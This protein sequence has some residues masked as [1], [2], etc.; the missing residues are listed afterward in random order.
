MG[1]LFILFTVLFFCVH[2]KGQSFDWG[3]AS[4]EEEGYSSQKIQAMRDTLAAHKTTSILVISNDKIILEWYAPGWERKQHGTAS[5][6]KALVGGMSLLLALNDGRMQVDDPACKF[7]PEWKNDPLRSKITIRQL[8]THSSGIEDAEITQKD[9]DEA[10]ARGIEIKDKHM[11]IPG[12]K[13]SFWRKDPD[14]FTISRD[15]APVLFEPGTDEAYSN[16]GMAMLAYAVTASYQGTPYKNIRTL[17]SDRIYKPIGIKDDEYSIGYG[18]TY[19]VNGLE[20]VANWGGASFTPRAAA[21]IGRLM[22]N[23]GNW[24]GRQL[25]SANWVEQMVA[26]AGTPIPSREGGD[27]APARGLAWYNNFDGVWPR[28]P[29]DLFFGSGAGN[30]T[31]MVIPSMHLIIVRNGQDMHDPEKGQPYHYG[32][33]RYIIDPLMDAYTAP[34]YPMSHLI[35]ETKFAPATTVIHKACDSD[36][37]PMTWAD[38][39][40]QYAAYGDG[41]GFDPKVDKK[42]SLG[43]AKITGDPDDFQGINIRSNTGEQIGH[44]RIGKKASGMLMVNGTLYMWLRNA[45]GN[46]EESQLAWSADHGSTWTYSGWNFTTGFGC[47]TF[48]NFGKNYH[49]A[50]DDFVYIYSHD[51]KDAYKPADQMVLARVAKDKIRDRS[52]YE[53]FTSLNKQGKPVWTKDIEKRGPVFIHPAMCYRSG[54]TYDAG[55]KRY[56]WCQ[57][58]PDSKH[59]QGSRFQG[60]FGIYEAAEPWGPW[61]TVYYTRDWDVGPGETSSLPTKWMSKDG[62]TCYL[63]YSGNDCFSVRKVE[64]TT[65]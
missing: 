64:F 54:I 34:P 53:F 26:Y 46:G 9:I 47:P 57:V 35:R 60:G 4:P 7:I 15:Q 16:P 55:L 28:A 6:A 17:L 21:R 50:K 31:L 59:P 52:A 38:D 33:M 45:N 51:E 40:A 1:R 49:G 11:D 13:G 2:A 18:K 27:I 25:V 12:W 32:E 41:S 65:K 30:Q 44:G 63:V 23:K 36:N 43:L 37:W 3:N 58:N 14:P 42:L 10:K 22:L 39:N 56:L 24:D 19:P 48:L 61:H 29:R 62:R 8:A 20:L 5:L